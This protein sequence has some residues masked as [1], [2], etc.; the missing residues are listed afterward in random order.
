MYNSIVD[1]VSSQVN[2]SIKGLFL[3]RL[4]LFYCLIFSSNAL[5]YTVEYCQYE[6]QL[7]FASPLQELAAK[8]YE[9]AVNTLNRVGIELSL[10]DIAIKQVSCDFDINQDGKLTIADWS[11]LVKAA[12]RYALDY[13]KFYPNCE[14]LGIESCQIMPRLGDM[15]GDGLVNWTDETLYL[16]RTACLN[17]Q[18]IHPICF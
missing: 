11:E 16:Q 15:N 10:E 18:I 7:Q 6:N 12:V 17:G 14:L 3:Q 13:A 2:L 4:A 1:F 8:Q 5:G 9:N